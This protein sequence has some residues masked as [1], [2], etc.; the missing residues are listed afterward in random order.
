MVIMFVVEAAAVC[1]RTHKFYVC[2][3]LGL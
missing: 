2:C 1:C 3:P